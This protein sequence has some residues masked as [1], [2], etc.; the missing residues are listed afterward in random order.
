M[1]LNARVDVNFTRVDVKFQT[2]TVAYFCYIFFHF[3]T[4]KLQGLTYTQ[5]KRV[6][7]NFARVD[8]NFRMVTVNLIL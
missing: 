1:D 5:N 3:D 4:D 6:D 7:V 2:F 8:V